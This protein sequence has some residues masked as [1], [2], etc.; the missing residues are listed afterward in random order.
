L[1]GAT[2][3]DA[4]KLNSW[5]NVDSVW[6]KVQQELQDAASS[7]VEIHLDHKVSIAKSE[8]EPGSYQIVLLQGEANRG[9]LYFFPSNAVNTEQLAAVAPLEIAQPTNDE[10]KL[11]VDYK[12]DIKGNLKISNI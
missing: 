7:K 8:L 12:Q 5:K 3:A 10:N 6:A 11:Q 2:P 1:F 4:V 9:E